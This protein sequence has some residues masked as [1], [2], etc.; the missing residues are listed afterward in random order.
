[1]DIGTTASYL[2]YT[3]YNLFFFS[4]IPSNVR[5]KK[6]ILE[7]TLLLPPVWKL[8]KNA[9]LVCR[10]CPPQSHFP[11]LVWPISSLTLKALGIFVIFK[12][13]APRHPPPTPFQFTICFLCL[14]VHNLP[15]PSYYTRY[16]LFPKFRSH[17]SKN[18]FSK[19]P[20]PS[21]FR[22]F[23]IFSSPT[24]VV[25]TDTISLIPH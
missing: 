13:G 18:E 14:S 11:C 21:P 7:N 25:G 10:P 17:N 22:N 16:N 23:W 24:R 19:L 1:M 6:T 8:K 9:S 4:E 5:Q 2:Y 15:L 20:P 12:K 3:H